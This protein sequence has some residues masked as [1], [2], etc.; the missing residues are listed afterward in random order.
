[1]STSPGPKRFDLDGSGEWMI[2]SRI[3]LDHPARGMS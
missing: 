3:A 2:E 1:M